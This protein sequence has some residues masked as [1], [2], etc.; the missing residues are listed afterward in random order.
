MSGL[1]IYLRSKVTPFYRWGQAV[2]ASL[3]ILN[4][5][6]QLQW[7]HAPLGKP[8]L[9]FGMAALLI[10]SL[11]FGRKIK[12]K[13]RYLPGTMLALSGTVLIWITW[14]EVAVS[15]LPWPIMYYVLGFVFLLFGI[16]QFF[17]D[18]ER[19]MSISSR[20]VKL[21]H[22]MMAQKRH[23]WDTIEEVTVEEKD[24]MV[25]FRDGHSIR[26]KPEPCD[27]QHLR[28]R[29]DIIFRSAHAQDAKTSGRGDLMQDMF[30]A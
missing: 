28:S 29:V 30:G 24:I 19:W 12:R 23:P 8:L 22:N 9:S 7:I 16:S 5:I 10:T 21:K 3:M 2:V 25:L 1:K 13:F 20:S 6:I 15:D 14:D 11:V 18:G 26:V 27:M 17:V 4:G